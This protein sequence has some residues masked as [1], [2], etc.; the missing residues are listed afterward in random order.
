MNSHEKLY[1]ALCDVV[2]S[3][4]AKFLLRV[5]PGFEFRIS[6]DGHD[7]YYVFTGIQPHAETVEDIGKQTHID[8]GWF[9]KDSGSEEIGVLSTDP[10]QQIISCSKIIEASVLQNHIHYYLSSLDETDCMRRIVHNSSLHLLKSMPM[11]MLIKITSP[12]VFQYLIKDID[13]GYVLQKYPLHSQWDICWVPDSNKLKYHII[14]YTL[15]RVANTLI[16]Y[17]ESSGALSQ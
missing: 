16:E 7:F 11:Q 8:T 15:D 12:V 1:K 9:L 6:V 4:P 3:L 10:G 13:D 2:A 17:H 14:T 5:M